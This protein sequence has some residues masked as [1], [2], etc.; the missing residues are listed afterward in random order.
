MGMYLNVQNDTVDMLER[1]T[2]KFLFSLSVE[3]AF[4][5]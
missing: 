5:V 1:N 4:Q 3:K 2:G